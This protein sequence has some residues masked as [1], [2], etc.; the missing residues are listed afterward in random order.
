[1]CRGKS[2]R[3]IKLQCLANRQS[4]MNSERDE[5]EDADADGESCNNKYSVLQ[6]WCHSLKC[7]I[8]LI[9]LMLAKVATSS[10][11]T[12]CTGAICKA[13]SH[14]FPLFGLHLSSFFKL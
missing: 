3:R 6:V 13:L 4:E 10:C 2:K 9:N 14:T 12:S 7:N 11:N 1:M 8:T 5:E